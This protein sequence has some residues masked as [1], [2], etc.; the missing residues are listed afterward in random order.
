MK[1][2]DRVRVIGVPELP[3]DGADLAPMQGI[4]ALSVGRVFPVV[5]ISPLGMIELEVGELVGM[6][7]YIHSIWLEPAFVEYVDEAP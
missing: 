7:P 3:S 2:G 5:S 6:A 1:P 4:F